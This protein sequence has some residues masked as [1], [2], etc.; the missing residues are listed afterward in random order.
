MDGTKAF[1]REGNTCVE[2]DGELSNSSAN[3][4]RVRQGCIMLPWLFNIFMDWCMRE[5]KARWEE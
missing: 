1:Y 5:M 4:V 3:G 2:V